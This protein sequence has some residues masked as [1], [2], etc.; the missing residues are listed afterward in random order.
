MTPSRPDDTNHLGA[1]LAE[2]LQA[3]ERGERPDR[4]A[5]LAAHPDLAAEL[6]AYFADHDRLN[7]LAAPLHLSDPEAVTVGPTAGTA[8]APVVRYFGDY[9]LTEE[10]AR[11]GMGVV[12]RARQV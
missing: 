10:I 11:G 8:S 7:R 2:Y 3:V 5:L 6:R 1:V 12:Y 9:E 4:S